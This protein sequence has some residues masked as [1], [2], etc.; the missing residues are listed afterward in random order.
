MNPGLGFSCLLLFS[1]V[2]VDADVQTSNTPLKSSSLSP[3]SPPSQTSAPALATSI[4][5]SSSSLS[6]SSPPSQ[7]S[8]SALATSIASSSST[9]LM[10][11][12][13]STSPPTAAPTTS[14]TPCIIILGKSCQ[15]S[16]SCCQVDH[17]TC[18]NNTCQCEG[19]FF[20]EGETCSNVSTLKVTNITATFVGER[21]ITLGWTNPNNIKPTLTYTVLG[22]SWNS[23]MDTT[24]TGLRPGQLYEI[25]ITSSIIQY[26]VTKQVNSTPVSIRTYPSEVT[27]LNSRTRKVPAS[28]FS[29]T[30]NRSDGVASWYIVTVKHQNEIVFNTTVYDNTT[31]TI[32]TQ[33][34]DLQPATTYNASIV[35][36]SG[37]RYSTSSTF[38]FITK[39]E[40]PGYVE[41]LHIKNIPDN[42]TAVEVI[43][44]CP[45]E[46]ERHGVLKFY[47]LSYEAQDT[48]A[49]GVL[50]N[51]QELNISAQPDSNCNYSR[52]VPVTPQVNYNFSVQAFNKYAGKKSTKSY[53]TPTGKCGRVGSFDA[54]NTSAHSVTIQWTKPFLPNGN[55]L[56]YLVKITRNGN[57]D[58]V[59]NVTCDKTKQ[60]QECRA[61]DTSSKKSTAVVSGDGNGQYDY[62]ITGLLSYTNYTIGI[63]CININ[64]T[65]EEN[66]TAIQTNMTVPSPPKDPWASVNSSST[67]TLFWT[68]AD[69]KD[70][71]TTYYVTVWEASHLT[72]ESF[73]EKMVV[74]VSGFNSTSV[75]VEGLRSYWN[76]TFNITAA[77]PCG[78]SSV[79]SMNET[80]RT[81]ESAPGKVT[82]FRIHQDPGNYTSAE[83]IF[84]CPNETERHGVIRYYKLSYEAKRTY[85]INVTE[86]PQEQN[87]TAQSEPNCNYSLMLPVT[88]QVKYMFTVQ[89]F[90]TYGGVNSSK[91]YT[92]HTGESGPV[93]SLDVLDTTAHSIRIQWTKPSLPNGNILGYLIKVT[94]DGKP[95]LVINVTCEQIELKKKHSC[96]TVDNTEDNTSIVVVNHDGNGQ[97]DFN[98]TALQ[99]YTDYTIVISCVSINGRGE[100]TKTTVQ[101]NMTVPSPPKDFWA[102][103]NSSSSV[104]LFWTHADHQD[105]PTT[106]YITVWEAAN[107]HSD[108]FGE[109]KIVSVSGFYNTSVVVGDLRSYWKYNCSITAATPCGNSSVLSLNETIRTNESAPGKVENLHIEQIKDNFTFVEVIFSCPK[110][111]ERHG[112]IKYYTLSYEAQIGNHSN[113]TEN[114]TGLNISAERE[115]NCSYSQ[116]VSVTPQTNYLFS[117]VA[118][119]SFSGSIATGYQFADIGKPGNVSD[120]TSTSI[121]STSIRLSFKPPRYPNGYILG[122]VLYVHTEDGECKQAVC[123]IC[124]DCKSHATFR[125]EHDK[126]RLSRNVTI[127]TIE[128]SPTNYDVTSLLSY[129]NYT[130]TVAAVNSFS[131]GINTSLVVQTD[132]DVP[133]VPSDPSAFVLNTSSV[134]VSWTPPTH[135]SGPTDYTI[136]IQ[137]ATGRF[138]SKFENT[139]NITV[140]GYQSSKTT[141]NGLL[142]SWRYMFSIMANTSKGASRPI[143]FGS[144][145]T[146]QE[147]QPCEVQNLKVSSIPDNFTAVN[148]TWDC[149]KERERNGFIRNYTV[150]YSD[151]GA[152]VD[153]HY[154]PEDPCDKTHSVI[155]PVRPEHD[156]TFTVSANAMYRGKPKQSDVFYVTAGKPLKKDAAEIFKSMAA[157]S[158]DAAT[159]TSFAISFDSKTLLDGTNGNIIEAG[160]LVMKKT[161]T[162]QADPQNVTDLDAW[163]NWYKWKNSGYKSSYRPTPEH[164]LLQARR[165]R[166][167][168]PGERLTSYS[169]GADENCEG[170]IDQFC[171][172]PLEPDTTYMVVAVSCTSAGCTSTEPFGNFKTKRAALDDVAPWTIA[173]GVTTALLLCVI[174]ILVIY[175]KVVQPAKTQRSRGEAPVELS[176]R[177]TGQSGDIIYDEAAGASTSDYNNTHANRCYENEDTKHQHTYES[178]VNQVKDHDVH[179]YETVQVRL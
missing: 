17:A 112:D 126:C 94:S 141:I 118:H 21:N 16:P 89:A 82:R 128:T 29:L 12:P 66:S 3:S 91:S 72:S 42:Y 31:E 92:T 133:S 57:D 40:P 64:G 25:V 146:T 150:Q 68:H 179:L 105:G 86:H 53:T 110:E 80:V 116:V 85:T 156:Y 145:I 34:E 138:S 45:N 144:N 2:C 140:N 102:S 74:S 10:T 151:S 67:V 76:Y 70:G 98:I 139:R 123:I 96:K 84:S 142:S 117:V 79:L 130:F 162:P 155:L 109:N 166:S 28:N 63:S 113:V 136:I 35:T 171:N 39:D 46:T 51:I 30:F 161:E 7:I 158:S 134:E 164:Y 4:T 168:S 36:V 167:A 15:T 132:I 119:D 27:V 48:N 172:G 95:D 8:K 6:P 135:K 54:W 122:Y 160:I 175:I 152:M 174:V 47:I 124:T 24:I 55:I 1:V 19:N 131:V 62:T 114:P 22:H 125:V 14:A 59:I 104:T 49:E 58:K 99:S 5:A 41:N 71:P 159:D 163:K 93:D 149:P 61:A 100:E 157:Q 26:N 60:K 143:M 108:M 148:L 87:I 32:R 153:G 170:K 81:K 101:T 44:S 33:I 9:Q 111:T 178:L 65:G 165:R 115:L 121:N 18:Y 11:T 13:S 38:S 169:V 129:T 50:E 73:Q 177:G 20:Q 78:N 75:L 120:F 56:G 90:N 107:L 154:E 77:T 83:V 147:S 52:V 69:H 176:L 103:V 137:Q 97:Y 37:D 127:Q 23:P 106:Y 43:F 88:P 173:F